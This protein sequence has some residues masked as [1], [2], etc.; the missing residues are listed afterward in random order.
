M[1]IK[2][3]EAY[4]YKGKPLLSIN[5]KE[6]IEELVDML[7]DQKI[8]GYEVVGA[9]INDDDNIYLE[10]TNENLKDNKVIK[11]DLSDIGIE[12]GT[13]GWNEDEED[14][15][16]FVPEVNLDTDSIKKMKSYKSTINK[17]NV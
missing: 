11:L 13:R 8:C 12:I 6:F 5:R 14:F 1:E 10:V 2:K 15:E 9:S 4:V 3:F 16:E 7:T 17:F